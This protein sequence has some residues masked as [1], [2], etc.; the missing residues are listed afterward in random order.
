[1]EVEKFWVGA[2]R[3]AVGGGNVKKGSLMAGQ[4]VGSVTEIKP[5]AETIREVLLD[6]EETLRELAGRFS[7]RR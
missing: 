1:M 6:A 2:L 3:S 7:A 4:S 5:I